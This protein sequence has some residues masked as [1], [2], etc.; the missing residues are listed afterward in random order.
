MAFE[1][2]NAN[3]QTSLDAIESVIHTMPEHFTIHEIEEMKRL[4]N[5]KYDIR[6]EQYKHGE[7]QWDTNVSIIMVIRGVK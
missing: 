3:R 5:E 2:I 6:E 1:M 7:K 4:A